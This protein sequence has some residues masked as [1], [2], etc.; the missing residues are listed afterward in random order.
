GDRHGAG[1]TT[2]QY[3]INGSLSSGSYTGACS[4]TACTYT[5]PFTLGEGIY[6]ITY[7]ASDAAGRTQAQ[8]VLH[9][10]VDTTTPVAAATSPNPALWIRSALGLPLTSP[11]VQLRWTVQENLSGRA[12]VDNNPGGAPPD[13]VHVTVVV[14]DVQG[15]PVRTLDA[16]DIAVAPGATY[17]GSTTWDG[18]G[19]NLTS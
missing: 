10:A 7:W 1:V 19:M 17:Q 9:V 18:K 13:K 4:T 12:D 16:G 2:I 14:Y 15:F 3:K 8:Q 5:G 11:T 6:R